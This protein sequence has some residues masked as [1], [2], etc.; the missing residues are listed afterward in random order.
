M[1]ATSAAL[2]GALTLAQPDWIERVLPID[3]DHSSGA[4]EWKLVVALFLAAAFFSSLAVRNWRK[5]LH[6]S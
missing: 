5:A 6:A 3:P 4:L 1:L 2:L